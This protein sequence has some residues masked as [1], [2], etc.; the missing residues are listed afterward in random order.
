ME[1]AEKALTLGMALLGAGHV[2]FFDN[3]S[4]YQVFLGSAKPEILMDYSQRMLDRISEHDAHHSSDLLLTLEIYLQHER[5]IKMTA[6]AL[7]IHRH[8]LKNRLDKIEEITACPLT[9]EGRIN[10]EL[11]L[12]FRRLN[13]IK[14]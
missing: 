12:A 1:Q 10:Y 11:A 9:G 7:G 5:N 8:T 4:L 6:S 2:S 13:R 14:S 3:I